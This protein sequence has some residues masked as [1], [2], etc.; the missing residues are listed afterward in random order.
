MLLGCFVVDYVEH[1][2]LNIQVSSH[3]VQNLVYL[4]QNFRVF[5]LKLH[6][7]VKQVFAELAVLIQPFLLLFQLLNR[8]L[9]EIQLFI[10]LLYGV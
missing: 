10:F 3:C 5:I 1:L 7:L 6:V 4:D 9:A 8:L 2:L